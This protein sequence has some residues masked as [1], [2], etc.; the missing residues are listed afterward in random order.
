MGER[1]PSPQALSALDGQLVSTIER[2]RRARAALGTV[3]R[4]APVDGP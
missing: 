2:L 3:R 4:P 1:D